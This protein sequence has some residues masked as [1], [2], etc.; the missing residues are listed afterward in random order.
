MAIFGTTTTPVALSLD[1][2]TIT[3]NGQDNDQGSY[4]LAV[5][6]MSWNFTRQISPFYTLDNKRIL[7]SGEPVGT[8]TLQYIMGASENIK[9]WIETFSDIC[10]IGQNSMSVSVGNSADCAGSNYKGKTEKYTFK[11]CLLSQIGGQI[12]RSQNGNLCIGTATLTF[13]DMSID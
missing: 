11:N 2:T 10:K 5:N 1:K 4:K 13:T 3:I 8:L 12:S 6:Q 7:I 9:T